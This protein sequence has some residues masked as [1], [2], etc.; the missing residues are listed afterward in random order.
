MY[1]IFIIN[2]DCYSTK[3]ENFAN[4]PIFQAFDGDS[5]WWMPTV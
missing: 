4:E 2:V 5:I 3:I 1:Y